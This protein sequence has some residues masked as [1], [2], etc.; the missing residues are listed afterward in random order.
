MALSLIKV[1]GEPV[2][3]KNSIGVPSTKIST[4]DGVS[5][6]VPTIFVRII[7]SFLTGTHPPEV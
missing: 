3:I 2:S 6:K 5:F 7:L 1:T 4:T